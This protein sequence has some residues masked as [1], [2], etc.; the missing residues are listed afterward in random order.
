MGNGLHAGQVAPRNGAENGRRNYGKRAYNKTQAV[1][2]SS[3][4]L[5]AFNVTCYGKDD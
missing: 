1:P 2:W 5:F 3:V 4:W